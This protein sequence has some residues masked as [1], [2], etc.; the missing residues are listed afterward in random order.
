MKSKRTLVVYKNHSGEEDHPDL[1]AAFPY[2][3]YQV[4]LDLFT[5]GFAPWHW[6]GAVEIFY[7]EKGGLA[8]YTP[9]GRLVFPAGSGGFINAGVLHMTKLCQPG[10]KTIQQLHIFDPSFI[11]GAPGS[12]I[13]QKFTT[14]LTAG[15]PEII[16]LFPENE[17]DCRLLAKIR[18]SFTISD[19]D[20]AYELNLRSALSE[21]WVEFLASVDTGA[22]TRVGEMDAETKLKG[23]MIY[24]HEHYP[25]KITAADLAAA[26][27]VSERECYRIFKAILGQSP[28]AYI[29]DYRLQQAC[30]EL[31]QTDAAITTIGQNCGLGSGAYFGKTFKERFGCTPGEFRNLAEK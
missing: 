13:D 12:R 8:Y 26:A 15:G 17:R 3:H 29:R 25:E 1:Q 24:I 6:H 14:P 23:M 7:M 20:P 19:A 31:M 11:A 10:R 5:D 2:V 21:I 16:P 22:P 27:F 18:D 4:E 28:A 30:Q 9:G